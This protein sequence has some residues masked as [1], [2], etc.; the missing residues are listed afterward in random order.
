MT[1]TSQNYELWETNTFL[2]VFRE[3]KADPLYWLQWFT[4]MAETDATGYVD[5]E[6]MPIM[7]RKLAPFVMPLARGKSVYDDSSKAFRFKP[8]Y[9]KL[10]DRIDPLMPLTRRV[11]I[12]ANMSQGRLDLLSPMER[13]D[14]IRA[15]MT[16]Q[17]VSAIRRTWNYMA[18]VALRDGQIVIEGDDYPAVTVNF[19][20]APGHTITLTGGARFGQAGVSI[21]DFIQLVMDTMST[22]PFGAVPVRATMGGGVWSVM[23]KDAELKSFLDL[24]Y[25]GGEGVTFE[26][27]LVAAAGEKVYKVGEMTVGGS[28]GQRI[29][30]WVDNSDFVH[31]MT[32]VTTR[33][34]GN[35]QM[36]FTGTPEAVMGYQ[37]F[38]A[39]ID[40]SAGYA[41][42]PIFPKNW[43]TQG[44]V[45]VEYITHK[46]APIMVPL[47]PNATLKA[48]VI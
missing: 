19:Q 22:S 26:R 42:L 45:E 6:Q 48:T 28:S 24:N 47:N 10:E 1:S 16:A 8:S 7:N 46:S 20:R 12:D 35:D 27:G 21:V 13:I 44:D 15:A 2:G 11:G 34:I 9:I 43:V 25:R 30:F 39:I 33:Y 41:P 3:V 32:G 4:N 31:P 36:L 37:A 29:E 17:H 23:R 40:R 18:A 14:L 5:F 38:G